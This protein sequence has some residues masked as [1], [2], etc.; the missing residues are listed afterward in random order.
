MQHKKILGF[1]IM[2]SLIKRL[3]RKIGLLLRMPESEWLEKGEEE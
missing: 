3:L 1:D 2:L